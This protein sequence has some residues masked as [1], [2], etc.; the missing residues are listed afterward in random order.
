MFPSC[1]L[2]AWV[3]AMALPHY[4]AYSKKQQEGILWDVFPSKELSWC[5]CIQCWAL[6]IFMSLRCQWG[7]QGLCPDQRK[8]HSS[9]DKQGSLGYANKH[10]KDGMRSLTL[11]SVSLFNCSSKRP[12]PSFFSCCH[13]ALASKLQMRVS[14]H[15][16]ADLLQV[17]H[18][19]CW[20]CRHSEA[21]RFVPYRGENNSFT[22]KSPSQ[23]VSEESI[24]F[25][26]GG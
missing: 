10:Q 9:R 14:R 24:V 2:S 22:N 21:R 7:G 16:P 6:W 5:I 12:R 1:R 8:N 23:N 20:P 15:Y 11:A 4:I 17:C 3:K 25:M 13:L 18:Q 19:L 26:G